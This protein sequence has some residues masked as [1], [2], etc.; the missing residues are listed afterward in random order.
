MTAARALT[1]AESREVAGRRALARLG[2]DISP[3]FAAPLFDGAR[4]QVV[5]GGWQAGKSFGDAAK[6]FLEIEFRREL[7]RKYLYWIVVT[8]YRAPHK[9]IDY[10][11][12]WY[13]SLGVADSYKQPDGGSCRLSLFGG[14]VIVETITARDPEGIAGEPCDGVL[15]V[16]AG[17]MPEVIKT[18]VQGRLMTRR[19]WVRYSGTLED[20]ENHSRW[21]WYAELGEAWL[22]NPPGSNT[23]AFSLPTWANRTVYPGGEHDPEIEYWRTRF[24]PYTFDRRIAARPTGTQNAAYPQL[25]TPRAESELLIPLSGGERWIDGVGGI[26]YGTMHPSTVTAVSVA[27]DGTPEGVAWV[28]ACRF[29]P[30]GDVGGDPI[31]IRK[32]REEFQRDFGIYRWGFDPNE[33]YA[34]KDT[35]PAGTAVS[36]S[37]GSRDARV[38]FL[39]ARLNAR[40]LRFDLNGE[41]VP[42]LYR[43]M[44]RVHYVKTDAGRW[45]IWR[46]DDDRTASLE[47]AIEVLDVGRKGIGFDHVATSAEQGTGR[48]ERPADVLRWSEPTYRSEP[49]QD[50]RRASQIPDTGRR[51]R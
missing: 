48:D 47:D 29:L 31:W 2:I 42:E 37:S 34:A 27:D 28:R 24:D 11:A 49:E 22:P 13:Q 51:E 10:L 50:H 18:Q 1:S 8:D 25:N 4:E 17:Q 16:E 14:A 43:E 26:D 46:H 21:A 7:G 32:Q 15:V 6:L 23:R 12:A 19:G 44:R 38:G 5:M 20:D 40:K 36:G 35:G 9:E 45:D 30:G 39:R 3:E 41:G 33:R